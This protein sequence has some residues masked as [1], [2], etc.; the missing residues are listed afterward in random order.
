MHML[1]QAIKVLQSLMEELPSSMH[2]AVQWSGTE[3]ALQTLL[4][5]YYPYPDS[6]I[7]DAMGDQNL[8]PIDVSDTS[9]S[10]EDEGPTE[11]ASSSAASLTD[12]NRGHR[13]AHNDT[14]E[15][16]KPLSPDL[17]EMVSK[18][19]SVVLRHDKG[20]FQ[21]RFDERALVPLEDVLQLPIMRNKRIDRRQIMSAIYHNDK[22]RFGP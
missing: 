10:Q 11:P 14:E 21:L 7:D 4:Q 22:Q 13:S 12:R 9:G 8:D 15:V 3:S 16:P 6:D 20:E 18:R 5:E 19:L 2:E 17:Q 1:A